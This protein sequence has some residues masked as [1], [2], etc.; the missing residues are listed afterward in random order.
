MKDVYAIRCECTTNPD[1]NTAF[2][3]YDTK[4]ECKEL[5]IPEKDWMEYSFSHMF[6]DC[7]EWTEKVESV[8]LNPSVQAI[9][10]TFGK[11]IVRITKCY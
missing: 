1:F 8:V 4:K 3:A 2:F 9:T 11:D 6:A 5:G 10:I 7:S